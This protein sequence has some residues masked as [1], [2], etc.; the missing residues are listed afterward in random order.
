MNVTTL[1]KKTTKKTNIVL[2]LKHDGEL[3]S[4]KK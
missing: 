2:T 3:Y 1:A 4:D